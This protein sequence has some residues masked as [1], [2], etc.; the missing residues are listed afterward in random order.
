MTPIKLL[1]DKKIHGLRYIYW[2]GST[3]DQILQKKRLINVKT[4][5]QKLLNTEKKD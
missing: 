3:G 4:S 2:V 5:Q 1:R